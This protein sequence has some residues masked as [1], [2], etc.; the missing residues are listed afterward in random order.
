MRG[1]A[2]VWSW[3]VASAQ[4]A[5]GGFRVTAPWPA[6]LVLPAKLHQGHPDWVTAACPVPRDSGG[7][8][9]GRGLAMDTSR[10][11]RAAVYEEL[12]VDPLIDT[13]DIEVK[14][15]NGDVLLNGTVPSQ[16]Q[17]S[18][19]AVAA[20][21]VGGVTAVH[22]LLDVAMPSQDYGDDAAL[23]QLA[24]RAL[25][26][27]VAVPAGVQA[28]AREGS[29]V[30]TGMVSSSSQRVAAENAVAGCAGVLSIS[31]DIVVESGP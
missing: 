14:V 24:N 2:S 23:G 4:P 20:R 26:A 28:S 13:D 8:R 25:A 18:E 9:P 7:R 12:R 27:N 22:N 11:I 6:M 19:A 17:C 30:L 31:N 21:R 16:A 29:V 1:E 3:L 10:D 15:L 5:G